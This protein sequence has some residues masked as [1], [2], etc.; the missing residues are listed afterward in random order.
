MGWSEVNPNV[1]I[2][3]SADGSVILFDLSQPNVINSIKNMINM[4]VRES[5][6]C[7]KEFMGEK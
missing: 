6:E 1:L 3:A 7:G 5:V 2:G 4:Y